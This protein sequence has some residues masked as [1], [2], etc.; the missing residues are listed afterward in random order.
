MAGSEERCDVTSTVGEPRRVGKEIH[1]I[2]SL[3]TSGNAR[4]LQVLTF[5]VYF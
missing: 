3:Y 5:Y 2:V 4:M 1:N